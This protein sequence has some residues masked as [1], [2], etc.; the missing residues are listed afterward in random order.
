MEFK[1]GDK[2]KCIEPSDKLS[3]GKIYTVVGFGRKSRIVVDG[4]RGSW[5]TFRFIKLSKERKLP[6]WF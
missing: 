1:I 4:I 6:A 2:V 3:I 5:Y